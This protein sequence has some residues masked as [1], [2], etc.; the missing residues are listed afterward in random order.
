MVSSKLQLFLIITTAIASTLILPALPIEASPLATISCN[1]H[2]SA[3]HVCNRKSTVIDQSYG[4]GE[5]PSSWKTNGAGK[6]DTRKRDLIG[7]SPPIC[8]EQCR[9]CN[10]CVRVIVSIQSSSHLPNEY[11]PEAWRCQCGSTQYDP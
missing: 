3:D 8:N 10:P 2:S 4:E 9:P 5:R 11:Y 6:K 7:S 1:S